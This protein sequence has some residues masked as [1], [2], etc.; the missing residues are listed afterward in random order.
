[1]SLSTAVIPQAIIVNTKPTPK[2]SKPSPKLGIL[3][4][5]KSEINSKTKAIIPFKAPKRV[6]T[7]LLILS[8]VIS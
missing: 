8:I 3:K 6:D 2:T 5:A 4:E 1:M 7:I